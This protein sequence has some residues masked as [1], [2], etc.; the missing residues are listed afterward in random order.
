MTAKL[1]FPAGMTHLTPVV[2]VT[3]LADDGTQPG[4]VTISDVVALALAG[5]SGSSVTSVAGRVG[6]V[7]LSATDISGLASVA[8]SGAYSS[9][10]GT[11][12][13]GGAASL[14]VGTTSGTVAAG[15]D[16]RIV[17]AVQSSLLAAALGVATLDSSSLLLAAQ[18]RALTGDTTRPAGSTVTTTVKVNGV[19]YPASPSTNTVP[20]VTSTGQITYEQLPAAALAAGVA[21]SNLGFTPYN[22]TN[23]SGYVTAAGA[24]TAA[25]VQTVA[26]RTGTVTLTHSDLTDWATATSSFLTSQQWTAGAV[27]SI[28]GGSVSG[29][30]LTVVG[31]VTSVAT[32]TGA[33]TLAHTDLT[34]WT[35][36][37][38]GFLTSQQWT[39]GAVSSITGGSVSGGVLTVTGAVSSVAGRTGAVVVGTGD[40]AG[41][42]AYAAAAAPVQTVAGRSG[43]VV[44]GT[45]DI[46]GLTAYA[47]AAA[48]VQT[49][50][51]RSGA[52]TLST[53]DIS[54]YVAPT[55]TAAAVSS[56]VNGSISGGVLTVVGAVTSVASRTGVV[57]L[58][59]SDLTDWATATSSFLTSQQWTAGAVSSVVGATISSG[60]LT[61]TTQ[62]QQWT[63]GA[64]SSVSG[65]T[66][67]GGV[68]TISGGGY[69][70]PTATTSVLGGV[71]VDGTSIAITSGVISVGSANPNGYLT[72]DNWTA[73]PVSSIVGGSVSGGVLT[74]SGGGYTLPT[75]TTSVLGGVKV[76]GTSITIA[77]GVISATA[78]SLPT[79]T[80]SV[81]GGVKV[82]GYTII[83]SSGVISTPGQ[84]GTGADGAVTIAG[85]TNI[86]TRDMHYTTLTIPA[87]TSLQTNGWRIYCSVSLDL[88]NASANSIIFVSGTLTGNAGATAGTAGALNSNANISH[89]LGGCTNGYAGGAGG[90]AAGTV[91]GGYAAVTGSLF[92]IGN[93]AGG[94]GGLGQSGAGAASGATQTGTIVGYAP[95]PGFAIPLYWGGAGT[96]FSQFA[97][98]ISGAGGG[99]GGGDGT[100]GG[101]GG[102]GGAGC[103][104]GFIA[105]ANL[106]RGAST[107]AGAINFSGGTGG[108]GG[109]AIAGNR[110]GGGGG[111]GGSGGIFTLIAG[112][113]TG[114]AVTNLIKCNGGNGGQG[115]ALFGT[116]VAGGG[117]VGGKSGLAIFQN[118]SSP[119]WTL[120]THYT[121]FATA[122]GAASGTTGGTG[123]TS[124]LTV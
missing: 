112:S 91:G 74:I 103:G 110:G 114:S 116:G 53:S 123:A 2:G 51:G 99:G 26:G 81:L 32:R 56:V 100:A 6:A 98:G 104:I 102:G 38:S 90:T 11:P 71:K 12:S 14:S 1:A 29:G 111:G 65:G 16:S 3:L 52:V 63:A 61:V 87:G 113:L 5:V 35:T 82:D 19:A 23:P 115:G 25:P 33:V 42:T 70:L 122:G 44:I 7:V 93:S 69:T 30:V 75:A 31:A 105:T 119:G 4:Y 49:V 40:I 84:F 120:N 101:G 21:V 28:A 68:L 54:G 106:N 109:S 24:A 97:A 67:S 37:T 17:G 78:Y 50:A 22:A 124:Q 95:Y 96:A 76:D 64:V 9:L 72:T 46:A 59:H 36:A 80:T 27:S 92:L 85:T 39:A 86:L 89:V 83:V 48:P 41:L 73:G 55:W 18:M 118:L 117:G 60:V 66:I 43:A 13:L 107:A 88:T 8:T 77:S 94:A 45:G 58:T 62:T 47:A 121:T 57:T 20:V 79:A 108:A 15:N 10:T 34:D